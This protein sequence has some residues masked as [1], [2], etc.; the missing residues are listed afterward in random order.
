MSAGRN[1]DKILRVLDSVQMPAR[2]KVAA[3]V[4]REQGDDGDI[5]GPV[6]NDDAGRLSKRKASGPQLCIVKQPA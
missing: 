3:P 2:H 4:N 6:L 1:V 5:V